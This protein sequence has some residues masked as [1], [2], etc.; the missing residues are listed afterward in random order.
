MSDTSTLVPAPTTG[1][2]YEVFH[3]VC[4]CTDDRIS[5]CG[6]NVQNEI[7]TD[8]PAMDDCSLCILAWPQRAAACPWGCSCDECGP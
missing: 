3:V 8:E 5:A 6:A 2:S 4:H 1:S 7:W